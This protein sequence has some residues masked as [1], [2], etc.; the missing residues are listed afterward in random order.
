MPI[1][2]K[3]LLKTISATYKTEIMG[4]GEFAYLGILKGLLACVN[5]ELH[6]DKILLQFNIDGVPLYKSSATQFW[7]ILCKVHH[8]MD[9]YEPF[10]VAIY[11]GKHKPQD[12]ILYFEKF[13]NE[14][15]SF[16]NGIEIENKI[17]EI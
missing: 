7:P 10:L 15:N 16:Q 1:S 9:I 5:S 4:D 14:L 6:D 12:R 11:A 2:S 13:V 17:F 8:P 3:T